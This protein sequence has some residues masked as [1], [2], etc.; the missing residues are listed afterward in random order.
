MREDKLQERKA[1]LLEELK[2]KPK[3]EPK[4]PYELF[5]IECGN[6]WKHLYE[7][8]IDAVA[9]YNMAQDNE[10]DR[11]EIHQVK[12]KFGGLRVYLSKYTDELRKMIIDAEKK[13]HNT[14]EI[15]GKHI[16]KP[17]VENYWIYAECEECHQKWLDKRTKVLEAYENK[18]KENKVKSES[19]KS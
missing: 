17:I 1:K 8:I 13:S 7:P 5:D 4:W 9:E 12:E 3:V 16:S 18:V 6:G 10:D 15:C 11:I 19:N 14:C 2:N